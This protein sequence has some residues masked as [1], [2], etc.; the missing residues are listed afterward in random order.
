M[1]DKIFVGR[2]EQLNLVRDWLQR[3]DC[4]VVLITGAGGI[5]KSSL[6]EKIEKQYL[7]D[8]RFAVDY[9]DLAEQPLTMINEAVH[10]V[11]SLGRENFPE[12][13]RKL[14]ELNTSAGD[15]SS[16]GLEEDAIKKCVGEVKGYIISKNKRLLRIIDTYEIA[17]RYSVYGDDWIGGI[18]ARLKEIPGTAFIL[19]GR[20]RLHD[21]YILD[22]IDQKLA[23]LFGRENILHIAL[24]GL[25]E[26]E[27]GDFFAECDKHRMIP[28]EMRKKL[29]LLTGGRP[30]LLS[31]AVEWLQKNIPLPV[32][33]E[34]SLAELEDLIQVEDSYNDLLNDFEF[35]LVSRV[36]E[37]QSP[38]DIATLY[39]AHID[40]RMDCKLLSLLLDIDER[41]G[42]EIFKQLVNLPFVKEYIGTD[43]LKCALHDEM[44]ELV[45]RHAWPALDI[46]GEERIRLTRKVIAHHYQPQID[47]LSRQNQILLQKTQISL[48]Q[49]R[50][51]DIRD[52]ER[53]HLEAE[54]VYYYSKLSGSEALAFF[55]QVF[56]DK[57]VS[58]VRDQFLLDELKRAG[59]NKN[60]IA[61]RDADSLRRRGK[62]D[63]ARNI[64]QTMITK[65]DLDDVDLIH[66][67]NALGSM[68]SDRNPTIAE[69]SF[70]KALELCK[71]KRDSR[72]QTIVHNNLGQLFRKTGQ[73]AKAIDQY[74]QALALARFSRNTDIGSIRNNLA[75]MY[76]LNG[77]L[78]EAD[79]MCSLSIA[80]H[81]K[82]G[83]KK[84]LAFACL[85]KANIDRYGGDMQ[86][87]E[88]YARQAQ[89]LFN[90]PEDYEGSAQVYRTLANI[91]RYLF[92]FEQAL[93]YLKRGILL[94]ENKNK[95][96]FLLLASL[97]QLYGR[98][99]RHF[100]THLQEGTE[101]AG[102]D[103]SPDIS[104]LYRDALAT[105][106]VSI[107]LAKRA[108]NRWE[109]A[110][111]Q[112]E[113]VLIK[114]L[115]K[116][117]YNETELN[118]FLDRVWQTAIDLDDELLKGYVYENRAKI[119]MRNMRYVEAGRAF[120][121]AAD[122]LI[123]RTGHEVTRAFTRLQNTLLNQ[124]FTEE[125]SKALASGMYEQLQQQN[126]KNYP[127]LTALVNLCEQ[128]LD[129]GSLE[130]EA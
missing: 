77:N 13:T 33:L 79:A 24:S 30:I 58:Y 114:L 112:I 76:C 15:T 19:A 128:I 130:S 26:I 7:V 27:M 127:K 109:V 28:Q 9:F 39:M 70:L 86:N 106:Q 56:Y 124:H 46:G 54:T 92:N 29:Q 104:N 8:D 110:R 47:Y 93:E 85:T 98:T 43:P 129:V 126:Y 122:Y 74:D 115:S 99:Y 68:D 48:S 31:L 62:T 103:R 119:A 12:F 59:L 61:L 121:E 60:K 6:L 22:E 2:S 32:M 117:S 80:E 107:D 83:Q 66:A 81:R 94:V 38:F 45:N 101:S 51:A 1:T 34:K 20:D 71:L 63:E 42:D 96:S 11:D 65:E 87:A 4:G 57:E 16:E 111:S 21:K 116:D 53:W 84:L 75:W 78:D 35:E 18:N 72:I 67:Y 95:N 82:Q 97:Y 102:N 37:L 89:G 41:K 49:Y 10:L 118:D 25:D 125:Q 108:G 3:P 100:A 69:E 36:R 64:C 52:Q 88:R 40:R 120:G 50:E 113:I 73:F 44:R 23:D 5:G 90:K 91:S 55:D 105:L 17:S 123:R 14:L